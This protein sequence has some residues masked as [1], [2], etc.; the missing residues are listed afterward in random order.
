MEILPIWGCQM[1]AEETDIGAG[2]FGD[3]RVC[4]GILLRILFP[5]ILCR[6][7]ENASSRVEHATDLAIDFQSEN[8]SWILPE[9]FH[10]GESGMVHLANLTQTP[11]VVLFGPSKAAYLGYSRNTNIEAPFCGGCMN[12]TKH[13]MTHCMLGYP[14]EKQCLASITPQ[15][16]FDAVQNTFKGISR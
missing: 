14:P 3:C 1:P 6:G 11:C 12:I 2:S 10:D 5:L 15:V 9:A 8:P 7:Q 13:W 4:P 16:V